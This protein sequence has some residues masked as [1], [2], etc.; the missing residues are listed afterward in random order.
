MNRRHARSQIAEL[1]RELATPRR[2]NPLLAAYRWRYELAAAVAI[3]VT[4]V[5]LDQAIGPGWLGVLVVGLASMT[6]HWP[7]ARRFV[8]ARIRAVIVQ[9][10]LRTAFASARICTLNGRLPAI[11]WTSPGSAEIRV[12]LFCPAGVDVDRI[13]A[14]RGVLAAACFAADVTVTPHPRYPAVVA[15]SVRSH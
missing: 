14:A 6:W 1:A 15:L 7:A 4:L 12:W 9:H 2:P 11:L 10:R 13:H 5:A 3:P 8:L